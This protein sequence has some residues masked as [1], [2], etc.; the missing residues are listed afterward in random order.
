MQEIACQI[1][2]VREV[3]DRMRADKAP[4]DKIKQKTKEIDE[5][6]I[7]LINASNEV[8][9]F[10]LKRDKI[11]DMQTLRRTIIYKIPGTFI[12]FEERPKHSDSSKNIMTDITVEKIK[13]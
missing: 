8:V 4:K 12:H 2:L 6:N 9:D 1:D 10:K 5:L 3:V 11:F 13:E 7:C